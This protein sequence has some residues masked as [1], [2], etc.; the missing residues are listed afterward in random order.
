MTNDSHLFRTAAQLDAKGFYPVQDNRWKRGE[1]LYLP[2]YEGKMVEA[3][4]HRAASVVINPKNLNRPAQSRDANQRR[5]LQTP[6]GCPVRNSGCRNLNAAGIRRRIGSVGFKEITI[7]HK[8]NDIYRRA[9]VPAV[10]FGNKVPIFKPET[11]DRNEWLLT[12]NFNALPFNFVT[13]TESTWSD[14]ELVHSRATP[15]H[16]TATDL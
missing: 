11:T 9:I 13:W 1:K 12:A 15:R 8:C 14:S 6:T 7:S 5:T 4:D 10:G 16:C 3:Y 2:L